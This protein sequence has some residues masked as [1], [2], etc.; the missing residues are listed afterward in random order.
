ME[1]TYFTD[2]VIWITDTRLVLVETT[3]WLSD[4]SDVDS[5]SLSSHRDRWLRILMALTALSMALVL[6]ALISTLP[7]IL[8]TTF[9]TIFLAA[10]I[11]LFAAFILYN[12]YSLRQ[13][14]RERI[15]VL[16]LYLPI[17]RIDAFASLNPDFL[18]SLLDVLDLARTKKTH[19]SSSPTHPLP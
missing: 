9:P 10:F 3:Y 1:I 16:R 5:T 17:G 18:Q 7:A 13:T 8:D 6:L 19:P 2:G 12:L 11:T 4:I 15:Y 14:C